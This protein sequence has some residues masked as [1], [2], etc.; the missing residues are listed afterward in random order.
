[1]KRSDIFVKKTWE[2]YEIL[3]C[4]YDRAGKRSR[5]KYKKMLHKR[6]RAVG[7]RKLLKEEL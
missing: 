7:K 1:M 6:N 4:K 2:W 5:S 3:Y